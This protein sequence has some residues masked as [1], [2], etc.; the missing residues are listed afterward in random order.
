MWT[1]ILVHTY[2]WIITITEM[3][4]DVVWLQTDEVDYDYERWKYYYKWVKPQVKILFCGFVLAICML[5]AKSTTRIFVQGWEK[6]LM[7]FVTNHQ[8]RVRLLPKRSLWSFSLAICLKV[9]IKEQ[10]ACIGWCSCDFFYFYP[11]TEWTW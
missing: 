2:Y 8:H 7:W 11:R 4:T 1:L 9:V 3:V 10:N 6:L 5:A